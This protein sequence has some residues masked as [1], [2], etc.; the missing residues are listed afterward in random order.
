MATVENL[1]DPALYAGTRR[2]MMEAE[3]LPPWCYT[4][5]DFYAREVERIFLK[6]WNF[7]GR[8][9]HIPKAGDYFPLD[10]AGVGVIVVRGREGELRAF[11]NNCRHRGARLVAGEGSCEYIICPYHSW[12][13]DLDGRLIGAA[14]MER[15]VGFDKADYPLKEIRLETWQGFLF[16]NFDPDAGSLMDYLGDL[17]EK[18]ACYNFADMTCTRRRE[19]DFASNWKLFIENAM[20]DYH[21]PTVHKKSIGNQTI[22]FEDSHGQ[23]DA[24]YFP[25]DGTIAVLPG[26]NTALPW[27]EGLD[28]KARH[29]SYFLMLYPATMWGLTQD[30]MWWLEQRPQ[31]PA[32][33]TLVVGSCFPKAAVAR[34]DFG[35]EVEKYYRR[36]DKSVPEDVEICEIQQAGLESPLSDTGRISWREPLVHTIGNWV[37]DRVLDA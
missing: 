1:F 33:T 26:E 9:D 34:P 4:S 16:V 27:I 17:P 23:W 37:L 20:E 18:F 32:K 8:A 21:T 29:G 2:P 31:G 30:C 7:I 36:W 12:T 15:T 14:A 10:L 11:A 25:G 5:K 6:V 19:L 24:G 22:T 28:E 13:Y 3:H 35:D